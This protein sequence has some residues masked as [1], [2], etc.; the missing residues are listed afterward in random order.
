[1]FLLFT[2]CLKNGIGEN[3]ISPLE[4]PDAE[5]VEKKRPEAIF[6]LPGRKISKII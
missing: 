3:L 6:I 4:K 1:M 5:A 2:N